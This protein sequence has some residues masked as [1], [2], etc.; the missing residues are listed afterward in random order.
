MK[1]LIILSLI[2]ILSIPIF[3]EELNE[4]NKFTWGESS[5]NVKMINKQCFTYLSQRST[6]KML[7][8]TGHVQ[9]SFITYNTATNK[10]DLYY[11][12]EKNKLKEV[13]FSSFFITFNPMAAIKEYENICNYFRKN[14]KYNKVAVVYN[15]KKKFMGETEYKK[16]NFS[17]AQ[18]IKY[19]YN[20]T[21]TKT[22]LFFIPDESKCVQVTLT[23]GK[24]NGTKGGL[25][26]TI[27]IE[28]YTQ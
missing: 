16:L 9:N 27:Y 20:K 6:K 18:E 5:A 22:I 21:L 15:Y 25:T 4:F 7:V 3:S 11:F 1:K 17:K 2:I 28:K 24:V 8:F 19:Y 26:H 23:Y 12:F 10:Y 13:I 14:L